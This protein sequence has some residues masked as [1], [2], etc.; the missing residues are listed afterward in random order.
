MKKFQS[1]VAPVFILTMISSALLIPDSYAQNL[2]STVT[3][4]PL[5]DGAYFSVDGQI[6]S[7]A[8]S[9]IWPAG[10]K[11]TLSVDSLLQGG[12]SQ[13]KTQ[14]T[15]KNWTSNIGAVQGGTNTII[16]TADPAITYYHANFDLQYALSLIFFSCPDPTNCA[17][18]GIIYVGGAPYSTT[19]DIYMSALSSVILTAAP[20]PGWVFTGWQPGPNQ[21]I[22]GTTD[23]VV[24]NGP[25]MVYPVFRQAR[26]INLNSSPSGLTLLADRTKVPTPTALEWGWDTTH[27][28]GVVSPQL[29]NSGKWWAFQSWS[30]GG[31]ATHAYTV[32]D[33]QTPDSITAVFAPAA[34]VLYATTPNGLTLS[35]DGRT[36]WTSYGFV[37][38]VGETHHFEAPAQQTDSTGHVWA[39]SSWSNGGPAAQD[40]TV[41]ASAVDTGVHFTATYSPMGHLTVAASVPNLTIQVDGKDCATPCD[42][43]RPVGTSVHLSTAAS[44]PVTDGVRNDFVGWPGSG[45]SSSDWNVTLTADPMNLVASY[46]VMNRLAASSTPPQGATWSMTPNSPDGFYDAQTMVSVGVTALPGYRFHSWSGDLTGTKPVGTLAMNAP[47]SVQAQLDPIPYIAPTGVSNAAGATPQSGVAPGS[48]VAIF[49][50]S[51]AT[52]TAVGPTSPLAQTLGGVTATVGSR[53]VP[54]FFVSPTQ[55]NLQLPDDLGLG[56]QTLTV[57]STGLPAVTATFTAVRNAPG[58]FSQTVGTNL[59]AIAL[60]EDGTAVTA[61]SPAKHGELLTVYGTGFGPADH[62]RPEGFPVPSDPPFLLLDSPT[63]LVGDS[64]ILAAANAFVVPGRIGIDAVQFRLDDTAPTGTNANLHVTING[65]D[66]N[67]VLLPIQ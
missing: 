28:L 20:N 35:I 38:G 41:P 23:T 37:W 42:V 1:K 56:A 64:A 57:N 66:S 9:A 60:H 18:P 49:G 39:F 34:S 13:L 44:I 2:G 15:F 65:Q 4:A 6:Y 12:S 51:F 10:S 61:D 27:T 24:L 45:S 14:F 30:D 59:F 21:N 5:P 43:I 67:T 22:Q 16:V 58:L 17:S 48:V 29:D 36:N 19:Q 63:I 55:I 25:V 53:Y 47:R 26:T 3:V 33:S 8:M 11:H 40:F 52:D 54:L 50:A 46:H 31:V 32:T 7:H 62:A